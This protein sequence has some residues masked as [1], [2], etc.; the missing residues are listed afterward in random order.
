MRLEFKS[1]TTEEVTQSYLSQAD[2]HDKIIHWC[3]EKCGHWRVF[4]NWS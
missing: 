3:C 2:K 4:N 1:K